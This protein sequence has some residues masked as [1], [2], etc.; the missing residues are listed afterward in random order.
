MDS[1]EFNKVIGALLATVFVVFSVGIVSDAMFA[2][3]VPE[4]PGYAI[5]AAEVEGGMDAGAEPAALQPIGPLLAS[6]DVAAGEAV[7]RRCAACH[8]VESGGA[9]KVGPNL[10]NTVNRPIASHEGFSYSASMQE[11]SQGGSVVW[12]YEHLS[13]FLLDPRGYIRGTA[14]SFAGLK[15]P[16]DRANVISYLRTLSDSLA[17]LPDPAAAPVED[18][19][20]EGE[21]ADVPESEAAEPAAEGVEE[22]AAEGAEAAPAEETA[23]A[24]DAEPIEEAA[25]AAESDE[26][27]AVTPL[28]P[29][30][31]A[32]SGT[33]PAGDSAKPNEPA[34]V[35]PLVTEPAD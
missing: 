34:T 17:P 32:A 31:P 14:M 16:E 33:E 15:K 25:P 6:A 28:A 22:P 35:T 7:F 20:A 11:F 30:A 9:N 13:N 23:P 8:T 4:N 10:W 29:E 1:F 24:Q 26:P 21:E 2:A 19:A 3:P 18:A 12:D 5:E 27:A